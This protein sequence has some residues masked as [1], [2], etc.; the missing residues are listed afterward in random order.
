MK[1]GKQASEEKKKIVKYLNHW[2][3]YATFA[4]EF[5]ERG[6]FQFYST[7]DKNLFS[8]H[9][10]PWKFYLK[11]TFHSKFKLIFLEL[12]SIFTILP[13]V[14][15]SQTK[16]KIDSRNAIRQRFEIDQKNDVKL[17]PYE[18]KLKDFIQRY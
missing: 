11:C 18:I 3:I 15:V 7:A 4:I 1:N 5:K 8:F 10:V 6:S 16:P 9:Y 12:N 13:G 2:I 14:K 17:N